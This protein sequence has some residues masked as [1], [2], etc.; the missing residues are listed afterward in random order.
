[1]EISFSSFKLCAFSF[2]LY[3]DALA[4]CN[5]DSGYDCNDGDSHD[6]NACNAHDN[7]HAH[8][9]LAAS[10]DGVYR[11]VGVMGSRAAY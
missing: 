6:D 9:A 2:M 7:N 10:A 5:D 4:F 11:D 8:D 1:M 3:G